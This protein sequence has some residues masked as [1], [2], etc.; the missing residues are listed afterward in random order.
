MHLDRTGA[1]DLFYERW[2]FDYYYPPY[3]IVGT[4]P[5]FSHIFELYIPFLSHSNI[6]LIIN[7]RF[8]FVFQM[9]AEFVSVMTEMVPR[10]LHVYN[11]RQSTVSMM[12]RK[13]LVK[14]VFENNLK[15]VKPP[16]FQISSL[17]LSLYQP[18]TES[19]WSQ[20]VEA[21]QMY[22]QLNQ[23]RIKKLIV[24]DL[25][26]LKFLHQSKWMASSMIQLIE[27]PLVDAREMKMFSAYRHKLGLLVGSKLGLT[28][29]KQY[30]LEKEKILFFEEMEIIPIEKDLNSFYELLPFVSFV[31]I[32]IGFLFYFLETIEQYQ[33]IQ[34]VEVVVENE[35]IKMQSEKHKYIS[36]IYR[37]T[38][39]KNE[40]SQIIKYIELMLNHA[41]LFKQKHSPTENKNQWKWSDQWKIQIHPLNPREKFYLVKK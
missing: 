29:P 16:T 18:K 8:R 15:L 20:L 2:K 26:F 4:T 32:Y 6:H 31:E 19:D 1:I 12:K 14:W 41:Y 24:P 23:T 36:P 17:D 39:S 34:K 22:N 13:D 5:Q 28:F 11:K 25:E 7:P 38:N 9:G 10:L 33:S 21:F 37:Y 3:D 30:S 35:M 40:I 27:F